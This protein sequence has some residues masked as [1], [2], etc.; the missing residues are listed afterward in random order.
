MSMAFTTLRM[1]TVLHCRDLLGSWGGHWFPP[2]CSLIGAKLSVPSCFSTVWESFRWVFRCILLRRTFRT[3]SH[4]L[5]GSL[6]AAQAS[7]GF[8]VT[9]PNETF[10]TQLV[11]RDPASSS[12]SDYWWPSGSVEPSAD[13]ILDPV[14]DPALL[15]STPT[16]IIRSVRPAE[17][18]RGGT[19]RNITEKIQRQKKTASREFLY[20]Q[21]R[22]CQQTKSHKT[23][24]NF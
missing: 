23:R 17:F 12:I 24:L 8:L 18:P 9:S 13:V 4:L 11:R 7:A 19:C 1:F 3:F 16:R 5:T 21:A 14:V 10:F 6:G 2:N 20:V 15:T 22:L